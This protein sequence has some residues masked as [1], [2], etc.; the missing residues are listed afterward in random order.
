VDNEETQ[1]LKSAGGRSSMSNELLREKTSPWRPTPLVWAAGRSHEP[2]RFALHEE[3]Y[4]WC[5]PRRK[6]RRVPVLT[7]SEESPQNPTVLKRQR[8]QGRLERR[9]VASRSPRGARRLSILRRRGQSQKC[10]AAWRFQEVRTSKAGFAEGLMSEAQVLAPS[11]TLRSPKKPHTAPNHRA[12]KRSF[13][14]SDH[15]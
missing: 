11:S 1:R 4:G 10:G 7:I 3:I 14:A 9:G 12:A 6:G 15:T 2:R 8:T 5:G 13:W